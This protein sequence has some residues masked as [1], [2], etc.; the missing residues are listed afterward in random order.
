MRALLGAVVVMVLVSFVTSCMHTREAYRAAG[1]PDEYAY[2]LAEHYAAL[3]HEAA[4]LREKA[5][6][7]PEAIRLMQQADDAARPA[8]KKLRELRDAYLAVHSAQTEEDLQRAIN[9][10]VLLV[11]RLIRAVHQARS[12]EEVSLFQEPLLRPALQGEVFA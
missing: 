3:V 8:V 7:P 4:D 12:G 9:D 1:S 6:T 2:V 5:T 11:A 10:A